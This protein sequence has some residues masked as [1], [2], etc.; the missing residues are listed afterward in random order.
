M[1]VIPIYQKS[2]TVVGNFKIL[3]PHKENI[4]NCCRI[5]ERCSR[6]PKVVGINIEMKKAHT[7]S[8]QDDVA[9]AFELVIEEMNLTAKEIA[10]QWT[11]AFKNKDSEKGK[12]LAEIGTNLQN[13]SK[14]VGDLLKEWQ[15]GTVLCSELSERTGTVSE[16]MPSQG[17][18]AK[19]GLRV[20]FPDG[21]VIE[22]D[23]AADTFALALKQLGLERVE[24]L[25]FTECGLPLVSHEKSTE[26]GQR[27]VE[28]KYVCTH[29]NTNR[30]KETLERVCHRLGESS[31]V[32]ITSNSRRFGVSDLY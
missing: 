18:A 26:Y 28:G 1:K 9:A 32:E 30:K 8:K 29:S 22:S 15:T 10:N 12:L 20:T 25:K 5:F 31:K 2:N 4:M 23:C 17:R 6:F 11:V 24:A 27:C 3:L 13:F 21:N 14:R 16:V 7:L 19:T